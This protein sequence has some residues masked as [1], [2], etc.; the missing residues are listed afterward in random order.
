M[1]MNHARRFIRI[2]AC[3]LAVTGFGLL[4][5][6]ATLTELMGKWHV[7]PS[8]VETPPTAPADTSAASP[9]AVATERPVAKSNVAPP[10]EQVP[11]V[12]AADSG[13]AD[14]RRTL[15]GLDR[16]A[17]AAPVAATVLRNLLITEDTTWRGVVDIE[18]WV[19]IAPQTTLTLEPGTVVR[20][21]RTTPGIA[22]APGLLVQGRLVVRGSTDA[23]V[24]FTP[25]NG[26][27]LAG[28][29]YGIVLL[30][31]EKKNIIEHCRVEGAV[32]GL[33]VSYST[34]TMSGAS[35]SSCG[36]GVRLAESVVTFA[37][38]E[39]SDCEVGMEL[40]GSEIDLRDVRLNGNADGLTARR[41][42][43][44]LSGARVSGCKG[45]GIDA[46]DTRLRLEGA[47]V[48]RCES[49]IVLTECEGSVAH[50]LVAGNRRA[51]LILSRSGVKLSGSEIT[52]NDVGLRVEDGRGI[53][54]GNSFS[55]NGTYDIY[56]A[57]SEDFR[58]MANW[59]G[60]EQSAQN[61][62]DRLYD[63]EDDPV[64]GMVLVAPVLDSAPLLAAP[65]SVAK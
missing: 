53:A 57:G 54:W 33:D 17:S 13:I 34:L 10:P 23:P 30:A 45:T 25:A 38:G 60:A 24:R 36:T 42:S 62:G 43:L 31:S 64:R 4:T 58:A 32:M 19:R 8:P 51:G 7:Q 41:S 1:T 12:P 65:N 20:F 44:Y 48:E 16:L 15:P 61:L 6:C 52:R 46:F 50:S 9:P 47:V 56:N 21:R 26:T 39:V 55:G 27:P 59:W 11:P 5:G 49:G 28:E 63:G 37:G 22:T 14:P 35:F 40:D 18:G 29:W 2:M 3:C